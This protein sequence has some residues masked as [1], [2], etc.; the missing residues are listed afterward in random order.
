[1]RDRNA[2]LKAEEIDGLAWDRMGGLLPA[3]VQDARTL[4]LLMLGYMSPEALVQTLASGFVT[5]HSRSKERL[6][7]KGETSGNRLAVRAVR[8]DCDGDALLIEAL[9]QGP[10]CH[11][12]T[13]SCFSERG[14]SGVGWLGMLAGIVERRAAARPS[15]SYTAKLL[16]E[17]PVR[18]AQKIGEEGVEVA[19][20]GATGDTAQCVSE[21]A[22][23]LYHLTVLMQARGFTWEDVA[24]ELAKRHQ[25]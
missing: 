13:A 24:A 20:A 8:A 11:L 17:G 25:P 18:I 19:L 5:F 22:D 15:E 21:T 9:P 10:T 6:W 16:A 14:P 2:P 7:T 23:L 12:G 4:Q 1:M 3:I